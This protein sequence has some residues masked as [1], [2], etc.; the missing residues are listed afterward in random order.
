MDAAALGAL[1][2][3]LER[4]SARRPGAYRARVTALAV[5]GYGYLLGVLVLVVLATV[6]VVMNLRGLA[7]KLAIPLVVVIGAVLKAV[8]VTFPAPQGLPLDPRAVPQFFDAVRDVSRR[9]RGPRVHTILAVPELNAA[10]TQ[11]P[12]LGV[13]GWYRNFLLVGLPLLQ[14]VSPE[15]WQAILAHEMGHLS[16]RHGRFGAW[17]YRARATWARLLEALEASQS[18]L[19]KALFGWFVEWYAPRFNAYTF[20]LA[21][22]HEYEADAAAAELVGP[23]TARRALTRIEVA[24]RQADGFWQRLTAAALESPDPPPD[25]QRQ[26][27]AALLTAPSD[28]DAT[29]WVAQAWRRPP[30]YSDTHPT[31]ADRLRALGWQGEGAEAPP[32]PA[33][34]AGPSAAQVY[35]GE[36]EGEIEGQFDQLWVASVREAW[37]RQHAE[38]AGAQRRLAELDAT[39][40]A[41]LTLEQEWER[42]TLCRALDAERGYTLA[43]RFLERVPDHTGARFYVGC[44]LLER[45]DARGIEHVE[46]AMQR[47]ANAIVEGCHALFDYHS[48]RGDRTAAERYRER[49]RQRLALME[50][51]TAERTLLTPDARLEAHDL[52]AGV[53]AGMREKLQSCSGLKEAYIARRPVTILPETPCYVLGIV[54]ERTGWLQRDA[55]VE[56]ELR[57]RIDREVAGSSQIYVFLL[58]DEAKPLRRRLAAIPG[59]RL[60]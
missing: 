46:Q 21:R 44:T 14:A 25:S 55:K 36:V 31:L 22:A 38:L 7:L 12:R 53:I 20:V 35:L 47:D 28:S 56:E 40:G 2:E 26:L 59:A 33:P 4:S 37:Q 50:R 49:A 23:E 58:L 34:L 1:V 8:W 19:G 42:I 41:E 10:I 9:L 52:A 6:F 30:D 54:P 5:L 57:M 32:P 11:A 27:R 15:E 17:L 13:F 18:K 51:A 48:S 3:R 45:E 43:E 24:A 60:V 39:G 16:R 29:R